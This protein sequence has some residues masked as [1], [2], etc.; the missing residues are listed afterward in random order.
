CLLRSHGQIKPGA[1]TKSLRTPEQHPSRTFCAFVSMLDA[2]LQQMSPPW[3]TRAWVY[4]EHHLARNIIWCIGPYQQK[5][6][7]HDFA[8]LTQLAYQYRP[9]RESES[10]QDAVVKLSAPFTQYGISTFERLSEDSPQKSQG[11]QRSLHAHAAIAQGM[12]CRDAIDKVYSLLGVMDFRP[13]H[14]MRTDYTKSISWVFAKATWLSLE[15]RHEYDVLLNARSVASAAALAGLPSWAFDYQ[16]GI[17]YGF[18]MSIDSIFD[19]RLGIR[20]PKANPQIGDDHSK[21]YLT[22][23]PLE[24]VKYAGQ[25]VAGS[26]PP[27]IS[28]HDRFVAMTGTLAASDDW[29]LR[30]C[31][32]REHERTTRPAWPPA[33]GSSRFTSEHEFLID[34][35]D[36]KDILPIRK[37]HAELLSTPVAWA[38]CITVLL[39]AGGCWGLMIGRCAPGDVIFVVK[40]C[41]YPLIIR[42]RRQDV[43]EF[44]GC[45]YIPAY[46]NPRF[47]MASMKESC[48]VALV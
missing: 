36:W 8:R 40:D 46:S 17:F 12:R 11:A 1:V 47:R 10:F 2:A 38:S 25:V 35:N 43:Y 14:Q 7:K 23:L 20:L 16:H 33:D 39:T 45:A 21:L 31:V 6:T 3:H 9:T 37:T 41:P 48:E 18:P 26:G 28:T 13:W 19:I 30:N 44:R 32:S 4:Q 29:Q 34:A 42:K 15:M 22:G 27:S 5:Y 24:F